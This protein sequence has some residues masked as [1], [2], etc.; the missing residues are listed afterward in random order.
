MVGGIDVGCSL[1]RTP[2]PFCFR[3]KST[4]WPG[5]LGPHVHVFPTRESAVARTQ[6]R[7]AR[8]DISWVVFI[9]HEVRSVFLSI[10]W[11]CPIR[12][13][14]FLFSVA[15]H[16]TTIYSNNHNSDIR[17]VWCTT[18][19]DSESGRGNGSLN[20]PDEQKRGRLKDCWGS[21]TLVW[22]EGDKMA[23]MC[24]E[25]SM[26]ST[27]RLTPWRSDTRRLATPSATLPSRSSVKAFQ[28]LPIF[29]PDLD[30]SAC[31]CEM[32]TFPKTRGAQHT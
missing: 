6:G 23:K 1:K 11:I 29:L 2:L 16:F 17:R 20:E 10:I 5:S 3:A 19:S 32:V 4:G 12:K 13:R 26:P 24:V 31:L 8:H 30:T 25:L 18:T 22:R 7:G 15:W 14:S 9:R 27:Y 28:V 21:S